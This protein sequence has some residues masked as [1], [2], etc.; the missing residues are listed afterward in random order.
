[1]HGP[2]HALTPGEV[3]EKVAPAVWM[4]VPVDSTGRRLGTGSG[5]VIGP[6]RMITNCHVL[7]KAKGILVRRGNVS[8]EAK[9]EYPD[10]DRDLCTL[11]VPELKAPAV[12]IAELSSV[13]IGNRAY[14]V[15]YPEGLTLTLSEGLISG[16]HRHDVT[17]IQT[18]APISPGS[19]GGGLFDDRGRLVGITTGAILGSQR[20]AQN[21][22]L[23]VPAEWVHEVPGRAKERLALHAEKRSPKA[24]SSLA[25]AVGTAWKYSFREQ[26][27]RGEWVFTVRVTGVNGW[28]I[29][30]AMAIDGG[31]ADI[32]AFVNAQ[33]PN[34][35]GRLIEGRSLLEFSPYL[36][37]V[38]GGNPPADLAPPRHYLGHGGG[39]PF[40]M[41]IEAIEREEVQV[42]AGKFNAVRVDI[43][44]N[45]SVQGRRGNNVAR[46]R[47]STWYASEIGRYVKAHHQ[48]W[49][50]GG[51]ITTDDLVQLL[52]YQP[53]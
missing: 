38:H 50:S 16:L 36:L 48:Q 12:A 13:K 52:E 42:P 37:S 5:V 28:T 30:E 41:R 6:E 10:V 1:V 15:G 21:L 2:A 4:V 31:D 32:K 19:S 27:Y 51:G 7:V 39:N 40:Q 20:L 53:N 34:F 11:T 24:A 8:H 47:H 23:A 25:P 43:S 46:F 45:R 49:D 18:S 29:E 26:R 14:V 35:A 44:G 33:H 17:P 22:N 3:F 9:L